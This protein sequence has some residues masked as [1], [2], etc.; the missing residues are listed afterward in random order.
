LVLELGLFRKIYYH[1][2][3]LSGPRE[4]LSGNADLQN[5]TRVYN[6]GAVYKNATITTGNITIGSAYAYDAKTYS[7]KTHSV[8]ESRIVI[9]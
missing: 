1:P 7:N 4:A 9:R 8:L 6:W 3:Q 5:M 2:E